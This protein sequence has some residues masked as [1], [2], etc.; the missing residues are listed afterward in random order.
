MIY[1]LYDYTHK[2]ALVKRFF[3]GL[4]KYFIFMI[5]FESN[6][7]Y[8]ILYVIRHNIYKIIVKEFVL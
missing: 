3:L 4:G 2:N 6:C 8:N 7:S 5:V 1:I